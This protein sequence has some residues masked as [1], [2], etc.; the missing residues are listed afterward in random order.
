MTSYEFTATADDIEKAL[1]GE[2]WALSN[3]RELT[4][5]SFLETKRKQ[6]QD[7]GFDPEYLP[8]S[9][10]D[11][12]AELVRR[13]CVRG[14]SAM[15]AEC[16]LGKTIMQ[17]SWADK[18]TE[19]TGGNVLILAPLAVSQQT[20]REAE[21]FGIRDV[22]VSRSGELTSKITITN[23]EQAEKF[24]VSEVS[25]IVLDESSILKS[26]TGKTRQLLIDQFAS[27]PYKLCCTATPAPN[28]YMELGN[29]A[30][31]LNVMSYTEMLAMFFVHDGG[32]TSKW[33]LKGHAQDDFWSWVS[34]WAD[35][36]RRPSDVGD[37]SDDEF[38]LPELR[39]H[40]HYVSP[41]FQGNTLFRMPASTLAEHRVA[42]RESLDDRVEMVAQLVSPDSPTLI[43]CDLNAESEAVQ[44]KLNC[45]E[46]K[47]ADK[48]EVKEERML[49]FS[50]SNDAL[51]LVTKPSI[52]GHGMNWQNCHTQVFCGLSHSYEQF[53]QAVRRSWRFGQT[54]PVDVHIIVS[55]AEQETLKTIR[56]KQR[57]HETMQE[58]IYESMNTHTATSS[59][60]VKDSKSGDGW[61][62]HLGDCVDVVSKL[63]TESMDYSVFSPPFASLYTYSD[64]DRDMG[65]SSDYKQFERHFIYLVEQLHRVIKAGRL[66]SVHCMNLPLS[67]TRDGEIGIR[68]F[69]GDII[70]W[71]QDAGFIYASEVCIWK[72]PV[73]AMQ[74]T[75][76]L[77]LLH[78]QLVKDSCM[79]RQG[80]PD[81]VCTFRKTGENQSPVAGELGHWVGNQD[82]FESFGR[83]SIDIWQRYASPIWTDI[84]PNDT[85]QYTMARDNKDE[86]H[87]CPLQL[88]VIERCLQLWTNP[89]DKVLSPFAGIGS[90]GYVSLKHD[91][92]FVGVELKKSYYEQALLNCSRGV[93][94]RKE[95]RLF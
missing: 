25:G 1:R 47:G 69:R 64:S 71:F 67:K 9:L 19:Q 41:E 48:L 38:T 4:Y 81:Y 79:S 40:E 55:E 57:D 59:T 36:A 93:N 12:Q 14:R 17:L 72:D 32:Q 49:A 83:L 29:H 30:E 70:R 34:T 24:D 13:A 61:T 86:R 68:D 88:S 58:G 50:D 90:E 53:Y 82:E 7:S 18:V 76:A 5:E 74:R 15:F 10:F 95:G 6:R 8:A 66:V 52:C 35:S 87:I 3:K 23:Y 78:K 75:K 65:N 44:N 77:G 91:R 56:R 20:K 28:D 43:W 60:Y 94:E 39:F 2:P 21:T 89:G 31:F 42:R 92:T 11:W 51:R 26:F 45:L 16:G 27:T 85:L 84:K 22:S 37:Y 62:M 73:T 46:V 54:K 80:I 33:R 63:P